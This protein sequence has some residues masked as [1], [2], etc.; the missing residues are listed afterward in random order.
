MINTREAVI[1]SLRDEYM[2]AILDSSRQLFQL[3][4]AYRGNSN[5]YFLPIKC[6]GILERKLY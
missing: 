1:V 2:R 3:K 4:F 5:L 6:V